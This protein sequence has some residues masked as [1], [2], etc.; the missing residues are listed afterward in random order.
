ML[1]PICPAPLALDAE[2]PFGNG[3]DPWR[4]NSCRLIGPIFPVFQKL[5]SCALPSRWKTITIASPM[6]F[7]LAK[8]P[9]PLS[10]H[11]FPKTPS[12]AEGLN[13]R[14]PSPGTPAPP[15]LAKPQKPIHRGPRVPIF[16]QMER[17]SPTG[18]HAAPTAL[19]AAEEKGPPF[20]AGHR[21]LCWGGPPFPSETPSPAAPESPPGPPPC[22]KARKARPLQR[23]N[24]TPEKHKTQSEGDPRAPFSS[25]GAFQSPTSCFPMPAESCVSRSS[26]NRKTNPRRRAQSIWPKQAARG[27]R[28]RPQGAKPKLISATPR[29]QPQKSNKKAPFVTRRRAGHDGNP[30]AFYGICRGTPSRKPRQNRINGL[31]TVDSEIYRW[32]KKKLGM[33]NQFPPLCLP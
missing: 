23:A 24:Q 3:K 26:A 31:A 30:G 33:K 20:S 17:V 19:L 1:I 7:H 25:R 28:Q 21:T 4:R 22:W 15:C 14:K 29:F 18:A 8:M 27:E 9:L 6:G 32:N 11:R 10:S 5:G 16:G 2:F 13:R 12:C